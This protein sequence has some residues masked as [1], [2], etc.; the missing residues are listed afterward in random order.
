MSIASACRAGIIAVV[1]TVGLFGFRTATAERITIKIWMHEH[2][3]RLP[4]DKKI[5]AAFEAAN[6]DIKIDYQAIAVSDYPTKLLTA[7]ASGGG[8]DVFN[9]FSG[10]VAQ[11]YNARVLAPVDYPGLGYADEKAL[12]TAYTSGLD[13]IR[14]AGRLYGVPTEVSN[15]AC[16]A[17]NAIWQEAGLDPTKD[18]P[19]TWEALPA[20]AEKLTKRDSNGVPIHR[21]FD[22]N[23]PNRA[24]SWL[25]ISSM[26]HQ[27][28]A[29]LLDEAT[30]QAQ[31]DTPAGQRSIQYWVDWANKWKLGGPQYTDART[32]FLGGKLATDCSWGVWGLP[33]VKDAKIAVTVMPLPR[34]ADAKHDNGSDAYAYYMMVNARSPAPVQKAAWK[35][36]RMFT[37][38]AAELFTAA[39]LFVPRK[40]VTDLPALADPSVKVFLDELKTAQF[41][42]RVVGYD[43]VLDAFLRGRDQ[44]VQGHQPVM[45]RLAQTNQDINAVLRREK[46][47]IEAMTH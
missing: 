10:L 35:F 12:A 6:P 7:F 23:W 18:F 24:V 38:D 5:I 27:L 46:T 42:P 1:A 37:D 36:V 41:T 15:W 43:Q 11:Y 13:G 34:W 33:Q 40:E 21:G 31:L 29:N 2:P 8:P 16:F 17:N 28:N 32:D 14:F 3:P 30:Y 44:M 25:G 19:K 9:A 39:G 45:E 20:L 47:K 22:F 4:I 26:M